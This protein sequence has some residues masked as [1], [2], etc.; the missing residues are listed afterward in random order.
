MCTGILTE[1]SNG[2]IIFARTLEFSIPVK[3]KQ[4]NEKGIIGTMGSFYGKREWFIADG[5]NKHGLC[6]STFYF[7]HYDKEYSKFEKE[8]KINIKD[9]NINEYILKNCKTIEDI[10]KLINKLN[11][12]EYKLENKPFSLHWLVCDKNGNCV[13]LEVE[14]EILKLYNN[15]YRV[16]TNSPSFK[17]QVK[18]V[19]KYDYLSKYTKPNSVSQ[20]TGALG[21]PGDSSSSSRFVRANFYIKNMVKESTPKYGMESALR[22]L[23]NFDIPLGSVVNKKDNSK[24]ITEYTVVYNLNNKQ[25]KYAPYGYISDKNGNWKQTEKPVIL[26]K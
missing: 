15:P 5:V 11:I 14:K 12:L 26:C 3:W 4:F 24:D 7:P 16:I 20:G 19:K 25:M 1:T 23:H 8:D 22:I 2:K 18:H 6:V 13:V 10:K 17:E 9:I 21:L